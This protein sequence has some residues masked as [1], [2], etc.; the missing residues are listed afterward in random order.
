MTETRTFKIRLDTPF[1]RFTVGAI[2]IALT[3][4]YVALGGRQLL[5]S[6][7]T[8][9]SEFSS[10]KRAIQ[11]D[12]GN[13]ECHDRLGRY[14]E[15]EARDPISAVT[16]YKAAVELNPHYGRYWLDL[17]GAH[18]ILGDGAGQTAAIERAV[19]VDP[20][21]PGIAWEA[22]NLYVA[23]GDDEKA[24]R[25]YTVVVAGDS[26]RASAALESC[27]RVKPDADTLLRD[28]VPARPEAYMAFLTFLENKQETAATMKVWTLLMQMHQTFEISYSYD[29]VRYLIQHKEVE[30]ANAVWRQSASLFGFSS[31]LPSHDNLVTN[32]KFD[33]NIL[34]AGFDWQYHKET[35][36]GLKLDPAESHGGRRSLLI[37]F[38]GPG[39]SEAGI[40][41]LITVRP[42]T[43][44]DFTAYY[45]NSD[46]QGAGGPHFT[47][48]DMY[49]Q[50]IYY[51]S[52]ELKDGESWKATT[53][54]FTTDP[55]CR[56]VVLHIRRIPSGSPIRG[57]LWVSDF[58]ISEK[59]R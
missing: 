15:L 5:S 47:I 14:Y 34:D 52:E 27:W 21:S 56:L 10:L 48:Q 16:E 6:L 30:E 19:E 35:S 29:Y 33:L 42:G 9:R 44:Y 32:P 4:G 49:S 23:R 51:E 12:P 45:K 36:V 46:M 57:K 11:L 58:R 38:D 7:L 39:V 8:N 3:C 25:E 2:A 53:G 31:Y 18:R 43:S 24:L 59:A 50:A 41:Q 37:T 1:R 13:A 22:A 40:F 17:A 28:V 26:S 20:M 54:E 55:E